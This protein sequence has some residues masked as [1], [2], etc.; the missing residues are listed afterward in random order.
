MNHFKAVADILIIGFSLFYFG[1]A[2]GT[3]RVWLA[4]FTL[5]LIAIAWSHLNGL[6]DA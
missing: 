2:V 3:N 5:V 1:A 6:K 4:L